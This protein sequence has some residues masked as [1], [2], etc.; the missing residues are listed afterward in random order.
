MLQQDI[1]RFFKKVDKTTSCWIWTHSTNKFGHGMFS[2]QGKTLGAHRFSFQLHNGNI[3]NGFYVCH[4]CDNPACVNPNH[5][6][7][8]TASDNMQDMIKKGRQGKNLGW[9]KGKPKLGHSKASKKIQTPFGIFESKKKA[10]EFIGIASP[11]LSSRMKYNPSE[12]YYI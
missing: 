11:S 6:W 12:Y 5:L 10:A 2:F 4:S 7:L 3:S 9:P 8:G 1:D